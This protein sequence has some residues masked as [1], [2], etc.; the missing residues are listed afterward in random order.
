MVRTKSDKLKSMS[1]VKMAVDFYWRQNCYSP[2]LRDISATTGLSNAGVVYVLERLQDDGVL[3]MDK[4]KS[5]TIVPMW[6]VDRIK[7]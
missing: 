4:Y 1:D 2:S 7:A 6:V 5:R 3:T